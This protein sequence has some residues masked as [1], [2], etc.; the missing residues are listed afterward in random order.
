M[1]AGFDG[2]LTNGTFPSRDLSDQ[3]SGSGNVGSAGGSDVGC[4]EVRQSDVR[5]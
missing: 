3:G 5:A 4:V 2:W 1:D